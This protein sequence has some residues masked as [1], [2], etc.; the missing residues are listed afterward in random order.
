[1]LTFEE[2]LAEVSDAIIL[3]AESPGS[4]CEL[5]AFSSAEKI[6][7]EKLMI[8]IDKK[9]KNQKSFLLTGPTKKAEKDGAKIIYA[10]L[11]GSGLLSSDEL[12]NN[13]DKKT[14]EF[15]SK[16]ATINKRR[17]NENAEKVFVNTFILELLELIIIL[18]PVSRNDLLNVYRRVKDFSGF[19]LVKSNGSNFFNEIKI[20]YIIKLLDVVE[21]IE[22]NEEIITINVDFYKNYQALMFNHTK[23]LKNKER[24]RLICRKYRYGV[25]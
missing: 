14:F 15:S 13:I 8:V 7:N 25:M 16:R 19:K 6:F 12:R 10:P 24:N 1:M 20:E 5:G 21:L 23:I 3:F 2:F 18:Q 17:P 11:D 4:F 22:Y 9:Y